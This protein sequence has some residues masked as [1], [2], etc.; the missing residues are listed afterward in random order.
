MGRSLVTVPSDSLPVS[1]FRD[2]VLSW[3][4]KM[5][6]VV[7]TQLRFTDN[8]LK[9]DFGSPLHGLPCCLCV[10]GCSVVSYSSP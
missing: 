2:L 10:L 8:V 4:I 3:V 5:W 6:T 7:Q 9:N 1:L